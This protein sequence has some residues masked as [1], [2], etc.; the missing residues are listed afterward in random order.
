M[1]DADG[2]LLIS[3]AQRL[4]STRL[5]NERRRSLLARRVYMDCFWSTVAK[6][7]QSRQFLQ[8][9]TKNPCPL[10]AFSKTTI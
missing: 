8:E 7:S 2:K 5:R 3:K 10:V 4:A 9:A 6:M 1:A